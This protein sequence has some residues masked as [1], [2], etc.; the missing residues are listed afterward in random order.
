MIEL[1][2]RGI[3]VSRF[4][5]TPL[6]LDEIAVSEMRSG[7][8]EITMRLQGPSRFERWLAELLPYEH[9]YFRRAG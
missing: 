5:M 9:D 8:R 3:K 2:E 7:W 4:E 6:Y 1:E